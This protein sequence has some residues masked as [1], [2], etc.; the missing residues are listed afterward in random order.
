[1]KNLLIAL[2]LLCFNLNAQTVIKVEKLSDKTYKVVT[3]KN[4]DLGKTYNFI[5]VEKS[6][7]EHK[8]GEIIV[9]PPIDPQKPNC[10]N[11]SD[12]SITSVGY[13]GGQID[14]GFNASNLSKGKYELLKDNQ[15]FKS[16]FFNPTSNV[17]IVQTGEL[18]GGNYTLKIIG[19]SCSGVTQKGFTILGM[20]IIDSAG[21]ENESTVTIAEP[22]K[23]PYY[24]SNNQVPSYY[25][26]RNNLPKIFTNQSRYDI[27]NDLVWLQNDKIKIGI[28][29][30][31][32]GQI[33]WASLI[34][35]TINLVYNGYDGGFQVTLDTYQKKDGYTQDGELAGSGMSG[36]P[37]FSYN[38]TQGGDYL[39]HAV[40]L[41]DYHQI[42]NGYYV[43]IRPIH[44]PLNAKL[45]ETYIEAWYTLDGYS[46]KCDYKY[47]SF[48][49]DGQYEGGGFDGGHAPVCFLVN[50]LTKYKSYT[51][52]KP[53]TKDNLGIEEGFIPNEEKNQ[54][55]SGVPLTKTSKE[56]W[57]LVY[58]PDNNKTIGVYANTF[59]AEN[60]FS[61]K[62]KEVYQ[63]NG[64]NQGNEFTGGYTILGRNYDLVPLLSTFN[65]SDFSK[66]VSS[67]LIVTPDTK[68][69][70]EEVYKKA[71]Y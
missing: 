67:Y 11:G 15:S 32:G 65:R 1:M 68:T 64:A 63:Q 6:T 59:D 54:A 2:S 51:G 39:N 42:P 5:V 70:I 9:L 36:S 46:V 21:P 45:S 38:V 20:P 57:S 28:N 25:D 7:S 22:N 49:T 53:W 48:R 30:K 33:A 3:D 17:V 41:L 40:T 16:D 35:D 26:N 19:E 50:T 52:N 62:Q 69:F 56:R 12:F 58:N 8:E 10:N 23:A 4:L 43:K 14:F 34:N 31:R 27:V 66:T 61:L 24:F 55:T 47:T 18:L 60:S 71:G 29:L 44:Y 37:T 13:G